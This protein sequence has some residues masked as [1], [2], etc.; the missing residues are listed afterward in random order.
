MKKLFTLAFLIAAANAFAQFP[1]QNMTMLSNWFDSSVQAEPT[2]GIK[3]SGC[4]GWVAPNGKEYAI[5]GSTAGTYFIDISNPTTPVVSDYVP[6]RRAQCIWREY[7]T[8]QNYCYMVS[9]DSSP[10]SFQ[11]ADMSYLP[12]SVHVV[13][14][15][16][17]LFER[18]HTIYV[19]GNKLYAGSVTGSWGYA[20]MAVY[21]LSNPAL[22]TLIR[23]L[24]QDYSAPGTVHD[25]YVRNDTVYA[26][27]GY[28]G[29]YIFQFNGTTF[30]Q[31]ASLTSYPDQGY[32]HSTSLTPDGSLMIMCDE[33]PAGLSVKAVDISDF[34]NITILD[35]FRSNPGA[36]AH[37]P[38]VVGSDRV[39]IAYYQ[40]GLQVFDISN[41]SSVTRTGYFDTDP[42]NGDNNGY[43][44]PAYQGC[45]GAYTELPS[46]NIIAGDMQNGLFV[47]NAAN[48]LG[49]PTS[50]PVSN[51]MNV[52]PNPFANSFTIAVS[53]SEPQEVIYEVCDVAGRVVYSE[54][55]S[56]NAG[57]NE[58]KLDTKYIAAGAYIVN[59]KGENTSF[60]QKVL[61]NN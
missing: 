54:S 7:R 57:I 50:Q 53:V 13:Y 38:Y 6:G 48:A 19:D 36:T 12:D 58:L 43:P 24:N 22:P 60:R 35:Q 51:T 29:F 10:N 45:W 5:I 37:N 8:Y 41:P 17:S 47:I 46:R 3:Y 61:C 15:G 27:G 23:K 30:T 1:A 14:D 59:V 18:A 32:N 42:Q 16:T 25:M 44:N 31:L 2:Y 26:S 11:I 28:E 4:Y 21:D 56:L 33:V 9:D 34:N 49:V 39:V 20:S 52:Y 55:A 40:D